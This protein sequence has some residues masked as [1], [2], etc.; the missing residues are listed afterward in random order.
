MRHSYT[1]ENKKWNPL[2]LILLALAL[3]TDLVNI[4]M[5]PAAILDHMYILYIALIFIGFLGIRISTIY[6]TYQVEYSYYKGELKVD[7]IY[8]RKPIT[9]INVKKSDI[10]SINLY[11]GEDVEAKSIYYAT[12]IYDRYLIE[13][14]S[15]EKYILPLDDTMY[16]A[17]TCEDKYDLFR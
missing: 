9:F 15:G 5:I 2:R 10:K 11:N 17:L 8:Y 6:M 16:A 14:N 7:K 1:Y 13:L 4:F 12:C 3:L